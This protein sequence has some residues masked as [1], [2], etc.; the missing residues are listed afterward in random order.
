[1]SEPT[2][3]RR[4]RG[5]FPRYFVVQTILWIVV[6]NVADLLPKEGEMITPRRGMLGLLG[7]LATDIADHGIRGRIEQKFFHNGE[8]VM[9]LVNE[10]QVSA[11]RD[12]VLTV[13]RKA[14]R[15]ASKLGVNDID[16][17]LAAEQDGYDAEQPV[18]SYRMVKGYLCFN[19]NGPIPVG[20][21][22]VATGI[23]DYPGNIG[24]DRPMLDAMGEVLALLEP[25][26][27]KAKHG[28]YMPVD[29]RIL[30]E[31]R[32]TLNEYIADQVTFLLRMNVAQVRAIPEAVKDKI[33]NWALALE[34][35]GVLG[36]NMTFSEKEKSEAHAITFN[37][38]NSK[39]EQLNNMGNNH[40]G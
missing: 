14:R 26:S 20:C 6:L 5:F 11:E 7:T 19:T 39:I 12:D 15:L 8:G 10:L 31:L 2:V 40:K 33:L 1:M 25:T 36:E 27:G 21:G 3:G 29:N 9:N 23:M 32:N 22:H 24:V 13:L 17:W 35:R 4:M 30:R 18:P 38:S 16:D 28:L 37:I 34:R